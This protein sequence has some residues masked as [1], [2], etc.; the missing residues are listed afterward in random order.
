V[1]IIGKG[2]KFNVSLNV[3]NESNGELEFQVARF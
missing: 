3:P 2:E 1:T